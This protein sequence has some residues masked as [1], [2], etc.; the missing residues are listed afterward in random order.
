MISG[1]QHPRSACRT[2]ARLHDDLHVAA[3]QHEEP[4]EAIE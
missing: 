3:K 2:R 4:H 1:D